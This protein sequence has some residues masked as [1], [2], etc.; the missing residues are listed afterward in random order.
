MRSSLKKLVSE[1][2]ADMLVFLEMTVQFLM[3][4][5]WWWR[6]SGESRVWPS[7]DHRRQTYWSRSQTWL[8]L[9]FESMASGLLTVL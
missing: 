5:S 6:E 7:M 8:K 2:T 3:A 9:S 4:V 1:P